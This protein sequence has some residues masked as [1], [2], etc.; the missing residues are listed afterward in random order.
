[1]AK[2]T[3]WRRVLLIAGGLVVVAYL[4]VGGY[5]YFK[6]DSL[7]FMSRPE[8]QAGMLEKARESGFEPWLNAKG[9]QIGW[10][11]QDGDPNNALLVFHGQGGN[12]FHGTY[13]AEL[14]RNDSSHWK[15]F[16]LEYPGYANRPG[17]ATEKSL[18]A[19]GIEAVDTLAADPHRKIWLLGHSLGSGIACATVR[20]RGNKIA[21]IMLLTPFNS[22]VS[23]AAARYPWMPVSA[24]LRTRLESDKNLA[25]YPGPVAVF[26]SG[27]DTTIPPE[28]GRR[29][30]ET[31]AGIKRFWLDPESDHDVTGLLGREWSQILRWLQHPALPQ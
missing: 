9:E 10:Q 27:K 1:M 3:R 11:S 22:L 31:F 13:Y 4:A 28:Q 26:V 29:L 6:Q 18:T 5:F 12:A 8:S 25:G 23:T 2:R 30:Y 24:L 21:G 7:I 19:A 15:T 16:L 17:I 20:Q 14:C